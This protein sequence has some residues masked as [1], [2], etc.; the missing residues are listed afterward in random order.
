MK[1]SN[2]IMIMCFILSLALGLASIPAQTRESTPQNYTG[3]VTNQGQNIRVALMWNSELPPEHHI[4]NDVMIITDIFRLWKIAPLD[5]VDLAAGVNAKSLAD[6]YSAIILPSLE[7]LS[8]YITNPLANETTNAVTSAIIDYSLN[9]LLGNAQAAFVYANTIY[10][11]VFDMKTD[12]TTF[13]MGDRYELLFK[14]LSEGIEWRIARSGNNIVIRDSI[15][16]YWWGL[17]GYNEIMEAGAEYDFNATDFFNVLGIILPENVAWVFGVPAF[18]LRNDD[19]YIR[20]WRFEADLEAFQQYVEFL[21]KEAGWIEASNGVVGLYDQETNYEADPLQKM[22]GNYGRLVSHSWTHP[23]LTT[24]SLEQQIEE[25]AQTKDYLASTYPEQ[26]DSSLFIVPNNDWDERTVV[27]LNRTGIPIFTAAIDPVPHQ[28]MAS[29]AKIKAFLR[30]GQYTVNYEGNNYSVYGFPWMYAYDS[31]A[32]TPGSQGDLDLS[33]TPEEWV[34]GDYA[35]GGFAQTQRALA[36][37]YFPLMMGTHGVFQAWEY[38]PVWA[39]ITSNQIEGLHNAFPYLR[40]AENGAAIN[41]VKNLEKLTIDSASYDDSGITLTLT[42]PGPALRNVVIFTNSITSKQIDHVFVD[43]SFYL[44]FGDNYVFLPEFTGSL[45]IR[46][47]FISSGIPTQKIPV[48][49]GFTAGGLRKTEFVG[50]ELSFEVSGVEP[51]TMF[52]TTILSI[53]LSRMVENPSDIRVEKIYVQGEQSERGIYQIEDLKQDWDGWNYDSQTG[54]LRVKVRV[55]GTET[56]RVIFSESSPIPNQSPIVTIDSPR[57]GSV[58]ARGSTINLEG[59]GVDADGDSLIYIWRSSLDGELGTSPTL[60]L[61]GAALSPGNHTIT[62]IVAENGPHYIYAGRTSINII[63]SPRVVLS[64]GTLTLLKLSALFS[65]V[66]LLLPIVVRRKIQELKEPEEKEQKS[67]LIELLYYAFLSNGPWLVATAVFLLLGMGFMVLM[68]YPEKRFF[69][70]A[71]GIAIPASL[72]VAGWLV[73]LS[74]TS[75]ADYYATH[76][77][78]SC[79]NLMK[80]FLLI[81]TAT[82]IGVALAMMGIMSYLGIPV[83]TVLLVFL[84]FTTFTPLW[85]SIGVLNAFKQYGRMTL[86]FIGGIGIGYSL[87][88]WFT[89]IGQSLLL[90]SLAYGIGYLIASIGIFVFIFTSLLKTPRIQQMNTSDYR[91]L[92]ALLTNPTR[93]D[94]TETVQEKTS[95]TPPLTQEKITL[96]ED[97]LKLKLKDIGAI[98]IRE[99]LKNNSWLIIGALSYATF[100]WVDRIFVWLATG[101]QT[102][103]FVLAINSNY[104]IGINIGLWVLVFTTGIIAYTF[105]DFSDSYMDATNRLYSE[106]LDDIEAGLSGLSRNIF[107]QLIKIIAM[108]TVIA[109]VIFVNGPQLLNLFNVGTTV[110]DLGIESMTPAAPADVMNPSGGYTSPSLFVLRIAAIDAVFIAIFLYTQLGLSYLALHKKA[111][112]VLLVTLGVSFP[113]VAAIIIMGFPSHYAILGHLVGSIAA[114]G[115]GIFLLRKELLPNTIIHRYLAH[116]I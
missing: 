42:N 16:S 74:A 44:G 2:K 112:A 43:D 100:V 36:E 52:E 91:H 13:V 115:V 65:G 107:N 77:I 81:T 46:M 79:R 4:H 97:G 51:S 59:T 102:S 11:V 108:A 73:A 83:S 32:E 47:N 101:Q 34:T 106:T 61:E 19:I 67:S 23:F 48:L 99:A 26:F 92:L 5:L 88:I 10:E 58:L 55:F 41:D 25:L 104:E 71:L 76:R 7:L 37:Y 109:I 9:L 15:L 103:G 24:L 72:I 39:E 57:G 66:L 70:F 31:D 80:R 90:I 8:P 105:K 63:I 33:R 86:F 6:T 54:M 87:S 14:N 62:L 27:A 68:G 29:P 60:E 111:A 28:Y 38:F 85:Y 12:G 53:D 82:I 116:Q 20:S 50:S 114:A 98:S 94:T 40:V 18:T 95:I 96:L 35:G 110:T 113:L 49:R 1:K 3:L 17:T 22:T 69:A 45:Q 30:Y 78:F 84:F 89:T 64:Q 56:I 75:I 21:T 93:S